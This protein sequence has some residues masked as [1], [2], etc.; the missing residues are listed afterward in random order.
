MYAVI[1]VGY[2]GIDNIFWAGSDPE[3]AKAKV[4]ACRQRLTEVLAL[5]D[6][7]RL[8]IEGPWWCLHDP[9][10]ICVQKQ[11]TDSFECCCKELGVGTDG[12]ARWY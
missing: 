7:E 6:D 5:S 2:E 8:D 11:T 4:L 1:A 3:E 12:P 9:D 10:R